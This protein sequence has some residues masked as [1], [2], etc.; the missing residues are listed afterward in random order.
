LRMT[1]WDRVKAALAGSRNYGQRSLEIAI[2][3]IQDPSAAQAALERKLPGLVRTQQPE[4][5]G[6]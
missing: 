6:S 5:P 2:S 1:H 3:G 4:G